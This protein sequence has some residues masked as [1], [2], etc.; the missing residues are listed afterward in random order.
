MAQTLE[1]RFRWWARLLLWCLAR[2]AAV[3]IK[4]RINP[5][6]CIEKVV[7]FLVYRGTVCEVVD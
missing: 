6:T 2:V 7:S 1:L 4:M 5:D 3:L